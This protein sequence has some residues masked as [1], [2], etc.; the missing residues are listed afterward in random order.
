MRYINL[1]MSTFPTLYIKLYCHFLQTKRSCNDIPVHFQPMC[2]KYINVS[3]VQFLNFNGSKKK[4]RANLDFWISFI[5][6]C[7]GY[8][9]K[10]FS[11]RK[12]ANSPKAFYK[13][14]IS[15]QKFNSNNR[16]CRGL[17]SESKMVRNGYLERKF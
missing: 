5:A 9:I 13:R 3:K 1:R 7:I 17:L 11:T 2:F 4:K 8:K 15:T 14:T 6:P 10:I 12:I 16:A